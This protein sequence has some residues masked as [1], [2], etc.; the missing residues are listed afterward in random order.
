MAPTFES[1]FSIRNILGA[2]ANNE[3]NANNMNNAPPTPPRS[4]GSAS[5]DGSIDQRPGFTYSALVAMAIRSSRDKRLPLSAIQEWISENYPYYRRDQH[6]WQSQVRHTLSTNSYFVKIPRPMD[7]PGR[8]NYWI[9]NPAMDIVDVSSSAGRFEFD[10]SNT[11]GTQLNNNGYGPLNQLITHGVPM[12]HPQAPNAVYFPTPEELGRAQC[13][14]MMQA[15]QEQQAW[16][17]YHQQQYQLIQQQLVQMQH[18]QQMQQQYVQLQ[19]QLLFHQRQC[20]FLTAKQF[21]L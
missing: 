12:N 3:Q 2:S 14:M 5:P 8:G 9:I 21:P 16:F 10:T 4:D 19:Q 15:L 7:D 1:N 18:Q 20:E 11:V 6:G 17:Q 13:A